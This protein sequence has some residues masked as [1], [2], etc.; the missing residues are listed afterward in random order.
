[1]KGKNLNKNNALANP[2]SELDVGFVFQSAN[3]S[4]RTSNNTFA[5]L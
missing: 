4:I 1:M 5:N 3:E 2:T